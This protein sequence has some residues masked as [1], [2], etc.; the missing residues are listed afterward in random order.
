MGTK[1]LVVG[2]ITL[3][4]LVASIITIYE[5]AIP[6]SPTNPVMTS[7]EST[8]TAANFDFALSAALWRGGGWESIS[9]QA[10]VYV[11][12]ARDVSVRISVVSTSG[13]PQPVR[14]YVES[15]PPLVASASFSVN[16]A[17]PPFDSYLQISPNWP[18]K[19]AVYYLTVVAEGG[20]TMRTLTLPLQTYCIV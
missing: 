5:F 17:T 15:L 7:F 6:Q 20:S 14:L 2:A 1:G 13:N 3:I 11:C 4:T 10:P 9:E 19:S 12:N 18:V 8:P 16:Y